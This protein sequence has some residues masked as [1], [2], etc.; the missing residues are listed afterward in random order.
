MEIFRRTSREIEAAINLMTELLDV[1]RVNL[2]VLEILKLKGR[3]K[4]T[5]KRFIEITELDR[6][7]RSEFQDFVLKKLPPYLDGDATITQKVIK[8]EFLVWSDDQLISLRYLDRLVKEFMEEINVADGDVLIRQKQ[9]EV[10]D[11]RFWKFLDKVRSKNRLFDS[12]N[13]AEEAFILDDTASRPA[14][15]SGD[16]Q[17]NPEP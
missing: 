8:K 16:N 7:H 12:F 13:E 15:N 6:K 17:V 1:I 4:L 5:D 9:L 10:K 11:K 14:K 2:E 3:I